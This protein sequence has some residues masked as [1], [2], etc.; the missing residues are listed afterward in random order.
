MV[1][2]EAWPE[3]W[4]LQRVLEART[5]EKILLSHFTWFPVHYESEYNTHLVGCILHILESISF[6]MVVP[7]LL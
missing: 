2:S 4:F 7:D 5:V 1:S 3:C 6:I